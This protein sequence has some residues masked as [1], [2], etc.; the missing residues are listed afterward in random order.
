MGVLRRSKLFSKL[1]WQLV[2]LMKPS[3]DN[4]ITSDTKTDLKIARFLPVSKQNIITKLKKVSLECSEMGVRTGSLI[5]SF[6]CRV[7]PSPGFCTPS[8]L[9]SLTCNFTD[10]I[11]SWGKSM[12]YPLIFF[13]CQLLQ[14]SGDSKQAGEHE[15]WAG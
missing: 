4:H 12:F 11:F 1:E 7:V 10:V 2:S 9:Y 13:F 5:E 15:S 6:S 14:M 3:L 8:W